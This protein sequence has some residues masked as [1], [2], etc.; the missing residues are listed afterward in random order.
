MNVIMMIQIE[1]IPNNNHLKESGYTLTEEAMIYA[2]QLVDILQNTRWY[3]DNLESLVEY[4]VRW[5]CYA[6][7]SATLPL[8]CVK[9]QKK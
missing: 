7:K 4:R 5:N 1:M 9:K 8:K 6:L 3:L 2:E